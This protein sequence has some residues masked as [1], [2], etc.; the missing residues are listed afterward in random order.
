M[1]V[2]VDSLAIRPVQ[3]LIHLQFPVPNVDVGELADQRSQY[4]VEVFADDTLDAVPEVG[5]L[6]G[7]PVQDDVDGSLGGL[8]VEFEKMISRL[9]FYESTLESVD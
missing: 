6:Q 4:D 8:E 5:L 7:L 9:R 3:H 1:T 2:I